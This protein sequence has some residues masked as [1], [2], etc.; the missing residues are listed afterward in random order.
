V[1]R[2]VQIIPRANTTRKVSMMAKKTKGA[3]LS[4][5]SNNYPPIRVNR[6]VP[7]WPK[8]ANIPIMVPLISLGIPL[9]NR[10]SMLTASITVKMIS[11]QQRAFETK[12]VGSVIQT[13]E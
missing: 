10:T 2:P 4:I 13:K 11:R 12:D 9:M 3:L 8:K 1:R 7:S 6:R 5:L